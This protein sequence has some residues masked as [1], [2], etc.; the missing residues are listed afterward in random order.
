MQFRPGL[1]SWWLIYTLLCV[2]QTTDGKVK[3]QLLSPV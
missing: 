1:K 3:V 2:K